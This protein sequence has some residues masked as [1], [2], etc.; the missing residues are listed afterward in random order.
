MAN[1][2]VERRN[3]PDPITKKKGSHPVGAGV[4]TVA[5]ATAGAAIGAPGGPIGAV[6]G[7][8]IGGIAGWLQGRVIAEGVNPTEEE[9]FWHENFS[10]SPYFDREYTWEDYQPAYQAGVQTFDPKRKFSDIEPE[11][12]NNWGEIRGDS[13]L[14]WPEARS[15][16]E[17]AWNRLRSQKNRH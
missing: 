16:S 14:E 9:L 12:E 1:E 3:N 4:G 13:R 11:L 17:D 15:A 7:A 2:S 6:A 8:V 10:G 5:G